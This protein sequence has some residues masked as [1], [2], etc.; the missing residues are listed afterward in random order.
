MRIVSKESK[1]P[2]DE[3]EGG[4]YYLH[5]TA[6][7]QETDMLLDTGSKYVVLSKKTF[8]NIQLNHHNMVLIRTINGVTANGDIS[9]YNVYM[10]ETLIVSNE[11]VLKNVEAVLMPNSKADI[12][13]V[14]VLKSMSPFTVNFS[15]STLTAL[16]ING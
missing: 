11:C 2:L 16:C 15:D 5:T 9:A 14:N 4:G 10:I 13:G 1:I 6:D 3:H 12:L 7:S 8:N